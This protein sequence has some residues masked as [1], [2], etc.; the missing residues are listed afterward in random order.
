MARVL[1][2]PGWARKGSLAAVCSLRSGGETNF[3]ELRI[4]GCGLRI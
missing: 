2:H 1:V 3:G 4:A